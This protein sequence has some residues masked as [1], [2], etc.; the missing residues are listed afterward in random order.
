MERYASLI[1]VKLTEKQDLC[2]MFLTSL[3]PKSRVRMSSPV[4][5]PIP[6]L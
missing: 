1:K 6:N 5:I 3:S 2:A 4:P